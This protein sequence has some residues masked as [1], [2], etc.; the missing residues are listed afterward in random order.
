MTTQ[1]MFKRRVRARMAKT[2]E[3]YTTARTQLVRKADTRASSTAAA[4]TTAAG[5]GPLAERRTPNVELPASDASL[6]ERT[7]HGWDH[8]FGVLDKWGARDRNH[9]EIARWLREDQGVDGWWAQSITGG[10]ERA[11]GM[12]AKHQFKQGFA[13]SAN[14]TIDV[15]LDE[16]MSAFTN[17][18]T[19]RRWL[20][21][22]PV[23]RRQTKAASALVFDW[24]DPPSR[25]TAWFVPKGDSK[26]TVTVEHGRLPDG[27]TAERFKG[28]WRERLVGLK[29]L[30][31]Q[32]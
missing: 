3:A 4:G 10:Y 15:P 27:E 2:G 28:E 14:R 21:G 22:A 1:K 9:T 18:T 26:T 13:V 24:P 8:W 12:R 29:K 16:L 25:I 23:Q 6:R 5:A 7:G 20:L 17:S 19:R 11:R 32:R 30:L 31:E